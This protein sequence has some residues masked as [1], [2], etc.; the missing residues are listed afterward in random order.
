MSKCQSNLGGTAEDYFLVIRFTIIGGRCELWKTESVV[1]S[2]F[3]FYMGIAN[4][5]EYNC[6]WLR[7]DSYNYVI[8]Y[9]TECRSYIYMQNLKNLKYSRLQNAD[10]IDK[11][12]LLFLNRNTKMEEMV[13]IVKDWYEGETNRWNSADMAIKIKYCFVSTSWW[14]WKKLFA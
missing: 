13:F 5:S 9:G 2:L 1:I 11:R 3:F 8:Y 4:T 14:L 12:S 10:V 6:V 7:K